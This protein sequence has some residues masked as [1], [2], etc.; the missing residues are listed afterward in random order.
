MRKL[1]S[2]LAFAAFS[3]SPAVWAQTI[4]KAGIDHGPTHSFTQA[5]ERFGAILEKKRPGEYKVQVYASAQLGNERIMQEALTLGSLEMVVTGIVNIYEPK[6]SLLEAPFLFRDREHILKFQRSEAMQRIAS[7]LPGKGLRMLGIVENGYRHITNNKRPINSVDDLKGLKVRTPESIAQVETFRALGALPTPMPFA[8]LYNALRQGI[9]DGQENPLQNIYDAKFYEAQKYLALTGHIYN[10]A[11][12][13]ISE[14]F[15]RKQKPEQ[16]KAIREA[17][18]EATLW[19]FKYVEEL[20]KKLLGM[21][22]EK[23]MQ[24]T[25]PDQAAFRASTAPAYEA[26]IAKVGP[27]SRAI[28]D[29]IRAIK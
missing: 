8:E 3:I 15:Y 1:L 10:S 21:L 6:F 24:V 19:Q 11:Y 13:L 9:V 2:A 28:L 14:Q 26:I 18:E 27:D 25:T 5:M 17:V 22:K 4:I 12:V 7:S 29:E 16:Q 20:D 23:G